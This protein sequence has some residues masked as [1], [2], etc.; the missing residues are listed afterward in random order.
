V[1]VAR[2][3]RKR[4]A[5]GVGVLGA[6]TV[7]SGLV[8]GVMASFTWSQAKTLCGDD[9]ICDDP[10]TLDQANTF[11]GAARLEANISTAL[12]IVGAAMVGVGA[13]LWLTAPR[14][15][16]DTVVRIAP[17]LGP[18]HAGLVIGGTFR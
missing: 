2:Q 4:V 3:T 17:Q 8:A 12:V 6:L 9:G 5:L 18:G 1:N 15:A 13:G 7:G 16:S 10:F 14:P 11:V